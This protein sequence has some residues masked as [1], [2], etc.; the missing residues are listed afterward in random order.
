MK[1]IQFNKLAMERKKSLFESIRSKQSLLSTTQIGEF[2]V[3]LVC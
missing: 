2:V 3:S 1:N